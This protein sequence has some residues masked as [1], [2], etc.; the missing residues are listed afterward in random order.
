MNFQLVAVGEHLWDLSSIR[1]IAFQDP[2]P[3]F[4]LISYYCEGLGVILERFPLYLFDILRFFI[5]KA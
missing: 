3:E 4:I 5:S 1:R 2:F